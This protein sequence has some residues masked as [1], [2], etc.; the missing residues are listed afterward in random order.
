MDDSERKS[1][2]PKSSV[3]VPSRPLALGRFFRPDSLAAIAFLAIGLQSISAS[4]VLFQPPLFKPVDRSQEATLLGDLRLT[5]VAGNDQIPNAYSLT[6]H[7]SGDLIVAGPGYIRRLR[8]RNGEL[9][10]LKDIAGAPDNGAQ[11][12][13]CDGDDLLFV[14]G[15]G[16]CRI[17][18]ALADDVDSS[19]LEVELL[20]KISTGGEHQA[21]AIRRGPD[22][23]WYLICGNDTD[24]EGVVTVRKDA[25]I[26][27]PRAGCL[28]RISEDF[29]QVEAF[30]HGFRNPYDFDFGVNGDIGSIYVFDSDGERDVS[31]PWYRPTRVFRVQ[32]GDDAGW[33]SRSWK[34]PSHYFDMPEEIASLG[35][36]SPTGV[37]FCAPDNATLGAPV[38]GRLLVA[39]W[40]FGRVMAVSVEE[41][42]STPLQVL[43]SGEGAAFAVTDME[44]GTDGALYVTVGGRGTEGGLFRID[45]PAPAQ[46][47]APSDGNANPTRTPQPAADE[48]AAD[49]PA[50]SLAEEAAAI[51]RRVSTPE[52]GSELRRLRLHV[53][54][55][56]C[57][58]RSA[59]LRK[60]VESDEFSFVLMATLAQD[61]YDD[62]A[63]IKALRWGIG[64]LREAVPKLAQPGE[65]RVL[66]SRGISIL[67]RSLQ[68]LM[69]GCGGEGNEQ[70]MFAGYV[71]NRP[72]PTQ[73]PS[74]LFDLAAKV[75]GANDR[76]NT[77]DVVYE[78]L[79]LAAMLH[80]DGKLDG[81]PLLK[82]IGSQSD[83][84]RQTHFLNCLAVTGADVDVSE[85][86]VVANA[87]FAIPGQLSATGRQTDRNW[88]PRMSQLV[89]R[90]CQN[91]NV[92]SAIINH[93]KFGDG[94]YEFILSGV[95]GSGIAG[96]G[97]ADSFSD[98]EA[99]DG[100][101]L[102]AALA[103]EL[104]WCRRNPD[105]VTA[106]QVQRL[107]RYK[108]AGD[109]LGSLAG[110]KTLRPTLIKAFA[111]KPET[112]HRLLF[113]QGLESESAETQ[114]FSV[115]GLRRLISR[116]NVED[117]SL[118]VS[119][120]QAVL[121]L[122]NRLGVDSAS[123][124][125]A[126]QIRL[127]LTLSFPSLA[128]D[129]Q[130]TGN[131]NAA[132]LLQQ[133]Q[134]P[135]EK[136]FRRRFRLQSRG[137]VDVDR[138]M[139]TTRWT[140]GDATRGESVFRSLQ[141]ANCHQSGRSQQI[142][143]TLGPSLEGIARRF[144]KRDLFLSILDPHRDVAD[145]YR[146]AI[147]TDEK[148][149]FE[150]GLKI[151]ESADGVTLMRAD[152]TTL[153]INSDAIATLE[154]SNKSLMPEGLLK[155]TNDT[156]RSDL[157]AF[158]KSL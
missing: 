40:T 98:P 99:N 36:G 31:L 55:L 23:F 129:F 90:L 93:S 128:D 14:G 62:E 120:T 21:H 89:Q 118:N 138:W 112:S 117:R 58:Q 6:S 86:P 81:E 97:I 145:R 103:N 156:Q 69:G 30:A 154:T 66:R 130:T 37:R 9:V 100:E 153:R 88:S 123:A 63:R 122:L 60:M 29:Q 54:K 76:A 71:A 4:G 49:V 133:V 142:S 73:S 70:Q 15:E 101:I 43:A 109:F 13:C 16:L 77:N 141:C 56:P 39:D 84:V 11:G 51:Q 150:I 143:Q 34:R 52:F 147:V 61:D 18:G 136:H 20:L 114:K 113:V 33:V 157:W 38:A 79:R 44:I 83:P 155:S 111:A 121:K 131:T 65:D 119:E 152:G 57:E 28:L 116:P 42:P 158:L 87:L 68:L 50:A 8:F 134:S 95:A 47:A 140:D 17:R 7:R 115:V 127:L 53:A 144:S 85:A 48:P 80:P 59:E 2:T 132:V 1:K 108:D 35:R 75:A 149:N 139:K 26:K 5:K 41:K 96:S 45:H 106:P 72:Y 107:S 126:N 25:A 46:Q 10:S 92:A 102:N 64:K 22:G 27:T 82:M 151:Y 12:L 19:E 125:V 24:L 137:V 135:L 105:R 78:L 104:A 110:N 94:E 3:G 124:S 146:T 74:D 148:G 32:R 67:V 91:S